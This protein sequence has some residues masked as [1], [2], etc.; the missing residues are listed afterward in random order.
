MLAPLSGRRSPEESF[1]YAFKYSIVH[2]PTRNLDIVGIL[3]P[4]LLYV[5]VQGLKTNLWY[6]FRI[7]IC[8]FG[9]CSRLCPC[10]HTLSA[11]TFCGH[12]HFRQQIPTKRWRQLALTQSMVPTTMVYVLSATWW[13][14]LE[15]QR[16]VIQ[17]MLNSVALHPHSNCHSDPWHSMVFK[18]RHC[19]TRYKYVRYSVAFEM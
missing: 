4:T 1:F 17:N 5:K 12:L 18:S 11:R 3:D 10:Y 15:L 9:K 16:H 6:S 8:N 2:P 19:Y 7:N 13:T 14:L